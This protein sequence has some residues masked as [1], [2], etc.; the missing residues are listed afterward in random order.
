LAGLE[1]WPVL[2]DFSILRHFFSISLCKILRTVW[3]TW[4]V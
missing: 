3:Y 2:W 1:G 4:S